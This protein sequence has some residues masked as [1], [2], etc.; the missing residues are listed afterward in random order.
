M[1]LTFFAAIALF[2]VGTIGFVTEPADR[3]ICMGLIAVSLAMGT[4]W[5]YNRVQTQKSE[6]FLQ[7]L[8][9]NRPAIQAGGGMYEGQPISV[10]TEVRRFQACVSLL[11][12]TTKFPSRFVVHGHQGTGI[13]YS[14]ISLLLGWWGIPWGPIFTIQALVKNARGGDKQ[15]IGDIFAK[16]DAVAQR[17]A[18]SAPAMGAAPLPG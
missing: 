7:F 10:Q 6:E 2:L 9:A 4:V 5:F 18:Q 11:F 15:K 14:L 8:V 1:K 16:L 13:A 12:I 3:P 17:K